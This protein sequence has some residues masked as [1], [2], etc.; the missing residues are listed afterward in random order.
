MNPAVPVQS[1]AAGLFI[2]LIIFAA[3]YKR[4]K[5]MLILFGFLFGGVIVGYLL[6]RWRVTWIGKVTMALIW[7]LLFLLGVEVG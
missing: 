1:G 7:L 6:R 2:F 3:V 5:K 4:C